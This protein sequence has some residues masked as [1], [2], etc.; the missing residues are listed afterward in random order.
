MAMIFPGMD[1]YLEAPLLWPGVHS[2]MIVYMRDQLQPLLQPRYIAA[3]EERVYLEGPD[4]DVIPDVRVLKP[5]SQAPNTSLAVAEGDAPVVVRVPAQDI[6]ETY[7][8]IL[9]R[10]SGLN[11]IAVLEVVSPTNKYAG[12]GRNS[13]LAKQREVMSGTAHLVE[14]DLLR[15]GPHVLAVPE[16][17]ARTE[18]DYD[19]LVCVNRAVDL[20][21][22]FELYPRRLRQRLPRVRIPLVGDDP[23][24]LL[25]IQ[26][27]IAQLY[28][29]GIYAQRLRYDQPC[30]PALSDDDQAWANELIRQAS[31]AGPAS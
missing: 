16:R 29:T 30:V 7:V 20:R 22:E 8:E 21:E 4:R 23:D 10:E 3:I 25:D 27:L 2:S 24:V 26:A 5:R 31:A 12:P 13:Y 14:I 6:H 1:P 11:V 28:E 9:D 19:Y 17:A 18:A 15:R